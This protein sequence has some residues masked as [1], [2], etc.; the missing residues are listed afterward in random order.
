[1]KEYLSDIEACYKTIHEGEKLPS[2]INSLLTAH[3]DFMALEMRKDLIDSVA[4]NPQ[5]RLRR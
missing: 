5:S 2:V 1:M 4:V 3:H